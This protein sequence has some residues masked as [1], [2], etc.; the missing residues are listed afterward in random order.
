MQLDSQRSAIAY[1]LD[2]TC[3]IA[4]KPTILGCAIETSAPKNAKK[5]QQQQNVVPWKIEKG[6]T[7]RRRQKSWHKTKE[8]DPSSRSSA[9]GPTCDKSSKNTTP[10]SREKVRQG[11]TTQRH[12]RCGGIVHQTTSTAEIKRTYL[13]KALHLSITSLAMT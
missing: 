11:R 1:S 5:K 9:W 4:K 6:R 2:H 8:P 10:S 3:W 12:W 7:A 13:T